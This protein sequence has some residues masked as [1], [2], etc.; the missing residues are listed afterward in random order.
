MLTNYYTLH[1][2]KLW[3]F[4]FFTKEVGFP[5]LNLLEYVKLI[6]A[7]FDYVPILGIELSTMTESV[8]V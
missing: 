3:R 4:Y 5:E 8:K 1:T 7:Y 2:N 6:L